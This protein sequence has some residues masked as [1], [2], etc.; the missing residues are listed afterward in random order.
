MRAAPITVDLRVSMVV[1]PLV[2]YVRSFQPAQS[3]LRRGRFFALKQ[4]PALSG[5]GVLRV[6]AYT[7]AISENVVHAGGFDEFDLAQRGLLFPELMG[8]G[9]AAK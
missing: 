1:F 7:D 6:R 4:I 2:S 9:M 3:A 5:S 8:A